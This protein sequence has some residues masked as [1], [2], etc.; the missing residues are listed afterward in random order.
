MQQRTLDAGTGTKVSRFCLGAMPFGTTVDE[1][2]AFAV[3]DRFV[4]AGG[5]TI[6]T[7]NCYS[8]WVPG[9]TQNE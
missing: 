5:T 8:F 3:L 9:G 6:D 1:K 4:E 7:A 2:T